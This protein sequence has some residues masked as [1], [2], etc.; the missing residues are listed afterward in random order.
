[1]KLNRTHRGHL[2]T[3][4]PGIVRKDMLN[5]LQHS[6]IR[7][8]ILHFQR[9]LFITHFY[10]HRYIPDVTDT[11]Q[12][13]ATKSR[14]TSRP[15]GCRPRSPHSHGP[16]QDRYANPAP[17]LSVQL[18]LSVDTGPRLHSAGCLHGF[19]RARAAGRGRG[20]D[21]SPIAPRRDTVAR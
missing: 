9:R 11:A 7:P 21:A 1:M 10:Q 3:A 4:C 18:S 6:T 16:R 8:F 5:Q 17:P 12:M 19:Q 15:I 13:Q 2:K 20:S 14:R